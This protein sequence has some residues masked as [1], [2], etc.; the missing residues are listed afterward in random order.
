MERFLKFTTQKKP[1]LT[2]SLLAAILLAIVAKYV[3]LTD[4]DLAILAPIFVIVAGIAIRSK[5][6]SQVTHEAEVSKAYDEGV[7]DGKGS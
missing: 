4:D 7:Q 5:V 3:N 1:A 2:A 6:F